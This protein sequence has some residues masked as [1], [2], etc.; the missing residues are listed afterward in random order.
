MVKTGKFNRLAFGLDRHLGNLNCVVCLRGVTA[1]LARS[2]GLLICAAHLSSAG[3][4]KF[5][6]TRWGAASHTQHKRKER[7]EGGRQE[8]KPADSRLSP[9]H[10]SQVPTG[11]QYLSVKSQVT[12]VLA[13]P[14]EGRHFIS[15]L[16]DCPAS[17]EIK[18]RVKKEKIIV[19][20]G[21]S[22]Q[23]SLK[24]H[25]SQRDKTSANLLCCWCGHKRKAC[26]SYSVVS[27]PN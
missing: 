19:Q 24:S 15:H 17:I 25:T 27:L 18:K 10:A 23:Q 21:H 8:G 1:G 14:S 12:T 7:S 2:P 4:L 16:P 6:L 3:T 11:R 20:K 9:P 26:V 22:W 13:E 5:P